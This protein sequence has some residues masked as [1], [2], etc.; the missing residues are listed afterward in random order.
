MKQLSLRA[1]VIG[2]AKAVHPAGEAPAEFAGEADIE[3]QHSLR[4]FVHARG[5]SWKATK[6]FVHAEEDLHAL[7]QGRSPGGR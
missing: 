1:P 5:S 2:G 6:R 4:Q 7:E 3:V